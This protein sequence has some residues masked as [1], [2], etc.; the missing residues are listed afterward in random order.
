MP[1]IY[2]YK[3]TCDDGGA[4]CVQDGLLSLAI[5]KPMIRSTAEVGDLIFGFA[6]KSLFGDNRLIYI[7]WVTDKKSE[8]EYYL[9]K[10]FSGRGD[11]IYRRRAGRFE[12]RT[13]ALYHGPG[14]VE[15]DLG[16]YPWYDRANVLLS[17]NLRYFGKSGNS[18]YKGRYPLV[19][20]AVESLGQGH[21]VNHGEAL[22]QELVS[23]ANE[24]FRSTRRK[25]LGRPTTLPRRGVS[26]RSKSCGVIDSEGS[27]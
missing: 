3:L 19:R 25:I 27:C 7:A 8:G 12:W 13:R 6:A 21:R 22:R 17:T 1:K 20:A 4:P 15:S 11:R 14:D 5:C 10:R 23:L 24:V 26:H 18:D 9:N 2:F 16:S